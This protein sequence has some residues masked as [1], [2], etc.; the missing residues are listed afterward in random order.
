[1][2]STTDITNRI[3]DVVV[4]SEI[5]QC[6][7]TIS[8]SRFDEHITDKNRYLSLF[9]KIDYKSDKFEWVGEVETIHIPYKDEMVGYL[10][11]GSVRNSISIY[12]RA[13]G[14]V[15]KDDKK[16][17]ASYYGTLDIITNSN[18][19]L[20]L[21]EEKDGIW[22]ILGSGGK[23]PVG[24]FLKAIADMP[25]AQIMKSI[26]YMPK[27]LRN[28][29][30]AVINEKESL[31]K[32]SMLAKDGVEPSLEECVDA[33]YT[34]MLSQ[35]KRD[36]VN[37]NS[38]T[39]YY[40]YNRVKT[41]LANLNYKNMDNIE[42]KLSI[43][44]RAVGSQLVD[45]INIPVF[46]EDG[47]IT[48]FFIPKGTHITDK[49]AREIRRHDITALR[50]RT[51]KVV[52]I[53]D[54]SSMYF[55]VMGYQLGEDVGE[56]KAGTFISESV[57]K[58]L[59]DTDLLQLK[60]VTPEG[61]KVVVRNNNKVTYSDFITILNYY[62]TS[63]VTKVVDSSEYSINNRVI[64]SFD[65]RILN[66]VYDIYNDIIN[67][68]VGASNIKDVLN[69]L[70]SYP[71]TSLLY[72]L[73][74]AGKKEITQP[75]LTNLLAK[76]TTERKS[77]ALMQ[78]A[79]AIMQYIQ[80]GQYGRLDSLH[81]P[82]SDK[83]GSV[84]QLT[85]MSKL[86][87][88]T[89]EILAPY[90]KVIDGVPTGEIE[91]I[92]AAK[93]RNKYIAEWNDPM[94]EPEV[95]VRV[96]GDITVVG[97]QQVDY[98]EVSPFLDM[99]LS[100]S[101]VPFPDY[102]QPK[103]SLMATTHQCQAIPL[104]YPE[105][106]LVTTGADTEIPCL[107]YTARDLLQ[108]Y[109]I[110]ESSETSLKIIK[111]DWT[112]TAAIYRISY[113]GHFFVHRSPCIVSDKETLYMYRLN[114]KNEYVYNMD[115]IV[116]YYFSTD[117][118]DIETWE[119][120]AQGK[121]PFVKNPKK[122][123]IA[124]GKNLRIGY[125]TAGSSTIEDA[126]LISRRLVTD[127]TLTSIQI[128]KYEYT[129]KPNESFL[130]LTA[131]SSLHSW[132][133]SGEP[134]ISVL[135]GNGNIK[136]INAFI[137]GEVI[138]VEN[139]EREANVYVATYHRAAVG[140]K[141]AG[142]YGNKSVIAKIVEEEMMPYD[143]ET[144]E[145]LD[146]CLSPLGLPSRMNYGQLLEVAIGAIMKKENKVAVITP[147]YPN[148]KEK[149]I[150]KCQEHGFTPKRLYLPDY[151]KYTERPVMVGI[152]YIL[153]LEQISNL[154]VS[155]VGYPV[156]VDS[157]FGQP[158]SS[159]NDDRGQKIG[160]ME[161]WTLG[162]CGMY[163]LLDD[164]FSFYVDDA[165]LRAKYF[166][167]LNDG[168]EGPWNELKESIKTN[169]SPSRN[170]LVTQSI[171][172]SLGVELV[173]EEDNFRIVPLDM[174]KISTTVTRNTLLQHNDNQWTK[175]SLQAAVISPF[176]L[177]KMTGMNKVFG[178]NS[179]NAILEEKEFINIETLECVKATEL[180]ETTRQGFISS[181]DALVHILRNTSINE[182]IDRLN[183]EMNNIASSNGETVTA[184]MAN[185]MKNSFVIT[186]Q[187]RDFLIYLRDKGY[188]LDIFILEEYPVIPGIFR[189][190]L[191]G[192]NN[193]QM[194]H[195]F[196]K[197]LTSILNAVS[198]NDIYHA[199]KDFIG[200]VNT[201]EDD[202]TSIANFFFGSKA[203]G[204]GR[205]RDSVFSKRIG[206]S[207]RAV[208]V[209]MADINTSP[210]FVGI[211]WY[212]AMTMYDRLLAAK[213]TRRAE[214]I[215]IE[216]ANQYGYTTPEKIISLTQAEWI[217]IITSL[218]EFNYQLLRKYISNDME[219]C[220]AF[221]SI[222]RRYAKEF[223]EGKVNK[224]GYV[225]HDG[226][227]VDP[228]TLPLETNIDASVVSFGRQPTLH[229]KSIRAFYVKIV[230]GWSIHIHP[231]VCGAFNAD[232]DGD[233]MW[234]AANFGESKM[235]ALHNM[236]ID[237]DLISDKDG[238]FTLGLTQDICL[239][240]YCMTTYKDNSDLFSKE[241]CNLFIYDNIAKLKTDVEFGTVKYYD[242]VIYKHSNNKNYISTAG[243]MIINGIMPNAFTEQ[244]FTDKHGIASAYGITPSDK[245]AELMF[246]NILASREQPG[247]RSCVKID[248]LVDYA[249]A[250]VSHKET[251]NI[252]QELYELGL[253]ASDIYGISISLDDI[254]VN[255]NVS[256]S[257]EAAQ[258]RSNE[259]SLLYHMGIITLEENR[260]M[261]H[262]IW[263]DTKKNAQN[264]VME[265]IRPTSNLYYMLYSGARGNPGQIMQTV[266]FVGTIQKTLTED[267][268]RP[269]LHGYG[270]GL[271]SFDISQT[272]YSARIGVVSTQ[273][274]TKD[275]GYANRQ[276]TYTV[277]GD[278]IVE[279]DCGINNSVF[280][281][282]WADKVSLLD[283]NGTAHEAEELFGTIITDQN[284]ELY[285]VIG[286]EI[287]L[288]S[289]VFDERIL[290]ALVSN[291][292]Y[293]IILDD[294]EYKIIK[295]IDESCKARLLS[296]YSYALPH[297]TDDFKIT[298]DSISFIEKYAL[299][300]V[301]A[302]DINESLLDRAK[303][304]EAYLP[305]DYDSE[306][307]SIYSIADDGS[308]KK[309]EIGMLLSMDIV[310]DSKDYF[311]YK[312]LLSDNRLNLQA[313]KYITEHKL[314]SIKGAGNV[315]IYFKYKISKL[316]KNLVSN[317]VSCA[318]PYLD[319]LG[320]ITQ[321]TLSVIEDEQLQFI[322][323]R[324]GFTCKSENGM[325]SKCYGLLNKERHFK[326][327]GENI[328]IAAAQS[329]CES[330]TQTTM[331][332]THNAG[333]RNGNLVQGVQYFT[334]LLHGETVP[335]NQRELLEKNSPCSA[336]VVYEPL[337][338]DIVSL[339]DT[340]GMCIG[341]V[342]GGYQRWA[343]PDGAYIDKNDVIIDGMPNLQ[344]YAS[345]DVF[346]SSLNTRYLMV[347][348]YNRVFNDSG[349]DI[350]PRNFEVL[351][352]A[353]TS[354]VYLVD[355]VDMPAI[356]DTSREVKDKTGHYMLVV[357]KHFDIIHKFTGIGFLGFE[358]F[359]EM[360]SRAILFPEQNKMSSIVSNFFTGTKIGSKDIE[361]RPT[362]R[363]ERPNRS[364]TGKK[365]KITND[366]DVLL[367]E[368][369][370][371][372]SDLFSDISTPKGNIVQNPNTTPEFYDVPE[373]ETPEREEH[374]SITTKE[375][376]EETNK[377]G[378]KNLRNM[379][380]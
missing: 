146:M 286:K 102:S 248:N 95:N 347:S 112:K 310:D 58:V 142:R 201:K 127:D 279:D 83:V 103:R 37:K 322:P 179:I 296:M 226:K 263:D 133:S 62:L 138:Y 208:I 332:T 70:K 107:Y 309:I 202:Y 326:S 67:N 72:Q 295:T 281:V 44:H 13:P 241:G 321:K 236:L 371:L 56:F 89:G 274:G 193:R 297:T 17:E 269:I 300:E 257:M 178:V 171:M 88:G 207:G 230:D 361:F 68:L 360:F 22:I 10:I 316:F 114:V 78:S 258:N 232:F 266:G 378:S 164:F 251:V 64:V 76:E 289:Y 369:F 98:R 111:V 244:P 373:E 31:A 177:E 175:I 215:A 224:Q 65:N 213:F 335:N 357:S 184:D 301:I 352:R 63:P 294:T 96:N 97:R 77:S 210:F 162:A 340:N 284:T 108:M 110:E 157:L 14:P 341:R 29:F 227:Y 268:E 151:N 160:E 194:T 91:Y 191:R 237:K 57:L 323:V 125:K 180:P 165:Q 51:S 5:E 364:N 25:Y 250:T 163:H 128:F 122:P 231:L 35:T 16:K 34:A 292:I 145:T 307:Y 277:M 185:P 150:E 39:F 11:D 189:Q 353:Q 365:V 327:V 53:Q 186:K 73:R 370:N 169:R 308:E 243:R 139:N 190:S 135:K 242:A 280:E 334:S 239:G 245:F 36:T 147:Y 303:L 141:V 217:K 223:V 256:E 45:D 187:W 84:H 81:A 48:S 47:N 345:K 69:K 209:P 276:A 319:D 199:I 159:D 109:G 302:L 170:S 359:N 342:S 278:T 8:F 55:R 314:H 24:V 282:K 82:Q 93:E 3:K 167:A 362:A 287:T 49:H 249:F 197:R 350:S 40:K 168:P 338:K 293:E 148:S 324:T 2:V 158:T 212:I 298:E 126:V 320:I 218:W 100:R 374:T 43:G 21:I 254:S 318:L 291:N 87:E 379:S 252:C 155:A 349:L 50:I 79:P 116:F 377:Q 28:S 299:N 131:V 264:T 348:L 60:V 74:S 120:S 75:D 325:C 130:P 113:D 144:G 20:S 176:W 90:E 123:A 92:T 339:I 105:R 101:L 330:A 99:S 27:E 61:T 204:H 183:S 174:S 337:N 137:T 259:A 368:G 66:T 272:L 288:S 233:S 152:M 211:P 235:E 234:V 166:A 118:R 7:I 222:A 351:A 132:V 331:N 23:L 136:E 346:L 311:R 104:L 306:Q 94:T 200:Y 354:Q 380:F 196:N 149:I 220:S 336:Y 285:T 46:D 121:L 42:A 203:I 1:M 366:T 52:T 267:I 253:T 315:T 54:A 80:D 182:V 372:F 333:K 161:T 355:P 59:N 376:S 214:A 181:I 26:A 33:V 30:P 32:I 328:G 9:S 229:K 255:A 375:S 173:T 119:L 343:V 216:M 313:I 265:A 143:P 106:A 172:R 225:W 124:L 219:V 356:K 260:A 367:G 192:S 198:P 115:D 275:T 18:G 19:K 15:L 240:L 290:K 195:S 358:R 344:R 134:V 41:Y 117:I 273:S 363:K 85:V 156:A 262:S 129:L 312:N 221:Y 188:D 304:D 6:N 154:K 71:D 305:V 246:D 247:N 12:Q 261:S 283:T 317:R 270:N 206:F 228:D 38:A 153:K 329:M 4:S 271:T 205:V 140:D 238:M 86:K